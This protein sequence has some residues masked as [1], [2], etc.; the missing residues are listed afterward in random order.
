[1]H[2][3]FRISV[4]GRSYTVVV[5][6]LTDETVA[7]S[8]A[9]TAAPSAARVAPAAP[10]AAAPT[11]ARVPMARSAP[12][13]RAPAPQPVLQS[14]GSGGNVVV[15]PLAGVV[16]SIEVRIGDAINEGDV[17]AIVEAMK[18]HTEVVSKVSG[19]VQSIDIKAK[20]RVE[21]GQVILT[22]G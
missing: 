9:T 11:P 6:E 3:M 2:R 14:G 17:V 4:D 19:T 15:A 8:V 16:E 10:R 18:M 13:P 12:A 1:M 21:T 7:A 22:V 20:E 5:E